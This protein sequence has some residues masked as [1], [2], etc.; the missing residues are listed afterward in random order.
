MVRRLLFPMAAVL[1]VTLVALGA[2]TAPPVA[3]QPQGEPQPQAVAVCPAPEALNGVDVCVNKGDG[4]TYVQGETILICVTVDIPTIA[5]FPPPPPPLVRV[6]NSVDGGPPRL[7]FERHMRSGEHCMNAVIQPPL[8][9]EVIR[10]EVINP[11]GSLFASD[12]AWYWSVPGP[13]PQPSGTVTVDRGPNSVYTVGEA[14]QI[15]YTLPGPGSFT[16]TDLLPDGTSHV[17]RSGSDDGTGDCFT[18]W[19]TPPTGTE[20]IR[21]TYTT[22]VGSGAAQ[23][24]FQVVGAPQPP[25]ASASITTDQG[26][27]FVGETAR[28]CYTVPG[29]G[30]VTIT[31][32]LADGRSHVL[33]SGHD[34]GTGGCFL[35]TVTLPRGI[36][37]LRLDFWTTG[38]TGSRQ[39]CFRVV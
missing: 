21:L 14:V 8:G 13:V 38:G 20:C 26:Q 31:D 6:T 9:Q 25:P 2:V 27:Y 17:L 11:D 39:T 34:D 3:A 36:E 12:T 19:V 23:V 18:A 35:A 30:Q 32:T 10:A 7:L 29:A 15:C 33:L 4:A 16:L 37:C 24:C 5:I 28:I 1:A 22:S